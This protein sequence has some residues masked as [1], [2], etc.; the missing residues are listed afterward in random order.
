MTIDDYVRDL[1]AAEAI[2]AATADTGL[3]AGLG[4]GFAAAVGQAVDGVRRFV[5]TG[6]RRQASVALV[7]IAPHWARLC[8][9][10]GLPASVLLGRSRAHIEWRHAGRPPEGP[11]ASAPIGHDTFAAWA[12][13]VQGGVAAGADEATIA[14]IALGLA[15]DAGEIANILQV[16]LAGGGWNA[17]HFAGELGDVAFHW[18]RLCVACDVASTDLLR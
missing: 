1:A 13:T 12:A 3:L 7:K 15:G 16:R 14:E 11:A 6:E 17:D 18:L 10:S 4:L 5:R 8:T 9:L 2:A